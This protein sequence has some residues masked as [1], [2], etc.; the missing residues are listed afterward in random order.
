MTVRK[1]KYK[2][3]LFE[4]TG[5]SN[6]T[7]ANIYHSMMISPAFKNMTKNQRLLYIC[8]K[9]RFYGQ[10]KPGLDYPDIDG[11]QGD[12]KFYFNFALAEEYGLYTKGNKQSLYNDIKELEKHGFIKTLSNGKSTHSRSIYQYVKDWQTWKSGN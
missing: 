1:K 9:D 4:S 5:T 11:L 7:S 2:P 6:D 8:M 10:R 12:D 3:K